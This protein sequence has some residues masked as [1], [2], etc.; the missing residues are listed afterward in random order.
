MEE[1]AHE[2][3]QRII[4][5]LIERERER[6]EQQMR[7]KDEIMTIENGGDGEE[8]RALEFPQE[9]SSGEEHHMGSEI[10]AAPIQQ[11]QRAL[12][13]DDESLSSN[14][15][16]AP[17]PADLRLEI[18]FLVAVCLFRLLLVQTSS[19]GSQS[20]TAANEIGK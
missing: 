11:R 15:D 20:F 3:E 10:Q 9:I 12:Y 6:L 17:I 1:T 2:R 18:S 13:F 16:K 5:G 19:G 14:E 8:Q 7:M 4:D